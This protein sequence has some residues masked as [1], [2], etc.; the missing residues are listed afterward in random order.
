MSGRDTVVAY[1]P[2]WAIGTGLTATVADV[3]E[4]HAF[5]RRALAE[6]FGSEGGA[7]RILYGGSVK[8]DNARTL[9]AVEH[10]NGALVGGAS[11]KADDFLAIIA[12]CGA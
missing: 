8:P 9:M 1:E 12:A 6:R 4:V 5:L 10:V 7:M 2:V 3:A 11:L